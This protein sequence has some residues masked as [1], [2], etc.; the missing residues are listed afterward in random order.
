MAVMEG[1]AD[2][3]HHETRYRT[4]LGGYRWLELRATLLYDDANHLVGNCGTLTDITGRRETAQ[5]IDERIQLTELVAGG[6]SFDDLPYGALLLDKELVVRRASATA[7]RILG[8]PLPVGTR[9]A[10]LLPIF[11]VHDARGAA[12][13]SEW[14]PLNIAA[15][16]GQTQY[17]ELRW[18]PY[19]GDSDLSLQ[20]TVIPSP[21]PTD[22]SGELVV[23]LQD[24]T[25]LRKAELRQ[26]TVARLGQRALEAATLQEL[27]EDALES[28]RE[29]LGTDLADLFVAGPDNQLRL[30]AQTGWPAAGRTLSGEDAGGLLHLAELAQLVG[31]PVHSH[32]I[33]LPHPHGSRA[34]SLSLPIH[35]VRPHLVLQTHSIRERSFR[36]EEV[37]FLQVVGGVLASA[38]Q[39]R[40]KEEAAVARSLHDPLTGLGNRALLRDR[41]EEAL[42][43]DRRADKGLA[44]MM[45]DLDRFKNINDTFGHDAGDEV[46]RVVATRLIRAT[47]DTDTVA[48]VGGARAHHAARRQAP[49]L[50][51]RAHPHRRPLRQGYR[52]HRSGGV[53]RRCHWARG[54]AQARR[55]CHVRGQAQRERLLRARS[56]QR[57]RRSPARP[58]GG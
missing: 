6:E 46:L 53:G 26:A 29:T 47:R 7:R 14:G 41:L 2:A 31:R 10:D 16:T 43:N 12:L 38:I 24:V 49:W 1:A 48:R 17:A 40:E 51:R 30:R 15:T 28:V 37:N 34:S 13:T 52:E 11:E 8:H 23:L 22:S 3:C 42:L 5:A 45:L 58:L 19:D 39:R 25:E 33:K 44:V 54:T 21:D 35:T 18:R 56:G 9:F 50:R 32:E 20:T 55:H 57:R 36:V 27:L 4:R